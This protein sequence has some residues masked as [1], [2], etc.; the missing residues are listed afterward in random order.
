[1]A[2]KRKI[3]SL[4]EKFLASFSPSYNAHLTPQ[5]LIEALIQFLKQ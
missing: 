5:G 2:K 3:F 4:E 1:L